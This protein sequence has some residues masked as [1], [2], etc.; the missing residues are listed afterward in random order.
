MHHHY[1]GNYWHQIWCFLN[2][3]IIINSQTHELKM[4]EKLDCEYV[5][6]TW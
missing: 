5:S 2:D 4:T 6:I 3:F 1:G